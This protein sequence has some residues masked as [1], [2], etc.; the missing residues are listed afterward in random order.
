M[1]EKCFLCS[2]SSSNKKQYMSRGEV[3]ITAPN[4]NSKPSGALLRHG[5][6]GTPDHLT[7]QPPVNRPAVPTICGASESDSVAPGWWP[8][9]LE[10]AAN[11]I[12]Q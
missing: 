8:T 3:T 7:L 2:H 11:P 9:A 1:D 12:G 4:E 5:L 10:E 6:D